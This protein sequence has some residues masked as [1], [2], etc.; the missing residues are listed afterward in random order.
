M[1]D[2]TVFFPCNYAQAH[3]FLVMMS[4]TVNNGHSKKTQP[5]GGPPQL[6]LSTGPVG[7]DQCDNCKNSLTGPEVNK[8]CQTES[9]EFGL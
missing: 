4:A 1:S 3:Q 7:L 8:N 6:G 5:E 2:I 9:A